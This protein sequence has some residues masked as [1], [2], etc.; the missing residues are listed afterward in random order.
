MAN[1]CITSVINNTIG[2]EVIQEHTEHNYSDTMN[3][4]MESN[5]QQN[6]LEQHRLDETN[7]IV[8]R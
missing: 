3:M 1:D 8:M 5:G 4:T 7:A 6:L 2:H